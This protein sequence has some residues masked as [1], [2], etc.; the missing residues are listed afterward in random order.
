MSFF[1]T[2]KHSPSISVPPNGLA[3]QSQASHQP[4]FPAKSQS[5]SRSA[6]QTQQSQPV[7]TWSVH[8]PPSGQ[9]PSPFLREALALSTSSTAAG[10]LFLFGG[11]LQRSK[12]LSNDLFV[13]STRD[14]STNLLQTSGEIPSPRYAHP[15]VL[16]STVLLIWGGTTG[17]SHR[18]YQSDDDSFYQLNLGNSDLLI[19]RPTPASQLIRTSSTPVSREWTRIVIKGP[20]PGG[21]YYH[22]MTLVGSKLFVFGGRTDRRRLNDMW[23]LDLNYC[24][25]SPRFPEPF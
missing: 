5:Q 17:F 1:R 9:S 12:S 2:K 25:F 7:R 4:Q 20:G 8:V 3:S 14:F 6:R 19:L 10:E 15:V 24:T 22:T 18:Q 21:R 11:Y 16:T 13:I 23:A